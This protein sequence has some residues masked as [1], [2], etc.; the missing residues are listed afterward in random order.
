MTSPKPMSIEE[1]LELAALDT[2]GLLDD[3]EAELFTRSFHHA[4]AGVQDEILR[5]QAELA[6][7]ESFLPRDMPVAQLRQKVLDAV[8][9][10]IE[11]DARELAP[12]ASI[13]KRF[14]L[15][16]PN[17]TPRGRLAISGQFW[18]AACLVMIGV[19]IVLAYFGVEAHNQVDAITLM[20]L[21]N[22]AIG[23]L[24]E[25]LSPTFKEYVGNPNCKPLFFRNQKAGNELFAVLYLDEQDG[26]AFLIVMGN[27]NSPPD[28][29]T[30][31]TLR[32]VLQDNSQKIAATFDSNYKITGKRIGQLTSAMVAALSWEIADASG[33]V[34]LS[35]V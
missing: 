18:R 24:E 30:T 3:F 29:D 27:A 17:P 14:A 7:D 4:P 26:S 13:G 15:S 16:S 23:Q 10:A 2:F 32:A 21:N 31:Y 8:A 19:S 5:I 28:A 12:L 34:I 33:T 22:N 20:A 11:E 35:T 9:R 25:Y 1:L 6:S